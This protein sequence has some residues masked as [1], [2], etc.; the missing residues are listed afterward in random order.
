M[1][2]GEEYTDPEKII[3]CKCERVSLKQ[4]REALAIGLTDVELLKRA[5][6]IGMGPCQGTYCLL[7]VLR[8]IAKVKG[9]RIDELKLPLS[10][11]PITP[12]PMRFFV[13]QCE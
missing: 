11:P 5:L 13:S 9:C 8:E 12:I 2:G 10:R 6:R 3:V 7:H 4:I 1:V